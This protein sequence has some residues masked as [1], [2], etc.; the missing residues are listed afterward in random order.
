MWVWLKCVLD[1][2]LVVDQTSI[3]VHH[4]HIN[5]HPHLHVQTFQRNVTSGTTVTPMG[6]LVHGITAVDGFH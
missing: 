3:H 4:T 1:I 6:I 5:I 2:S